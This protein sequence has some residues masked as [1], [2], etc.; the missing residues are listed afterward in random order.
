MLT[1]TIILCHEQN[2]TPYL[3]SSIFIF[4]M[5]TGLPKKEHWCGLPFPPPGNLPDSGI[6]PTSPVPPALAGGFFTT[7]PSGKPQTFRQ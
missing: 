5:S 7:E 2:L 4:N 1:E 3:F 6:K